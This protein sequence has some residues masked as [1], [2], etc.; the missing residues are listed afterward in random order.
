LNIFFKSRFLYFILALLTIVAATFA[1]ITKIQVFSFEAASF[2][3]VP[4]SEKRTL[5]IVFFGDAMFDRSVRSLMNQNGFD[6]PFAHVTDFVRSHDLAVLNLEGVYTRHESVSVKDLTRLQF[7]FDPQGID[8]LKKAG[9]SAVSQANNH[10]F[11]FGREGLVESKVSLSAR[12]IDPFG[13]YFNETDPLLIEKK[14]QKIAL[15]GFNE[16]GGRNHDRID[17]GIIKAKNDGYIAIVFAHWG[18]EYERFPNDFQKETAR[19]FIDMGADV[20]IGAHPH[21][22]EP[23]EEYKGKPIFYSLGNFIFDQYFSKDTQEGIALTL[24]VN[25]REIDF[26]VTP[27]KIERTVPMFMEQAEETEILEALAMDSEVSSEWREGI[28]TKT[29]I[30][31]PR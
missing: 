28:R 18:E 26:F 22:I 31:I 16:F 11:D 12:G 7:T 1:V 21:V 25:K 17:S 15:I 6:Y 30:K 19:H 3:A 27:F 10:S 14:G 8:A 20:V 29:K 5:T 13:D 4:A 23:I 9:F 2:G 24:E